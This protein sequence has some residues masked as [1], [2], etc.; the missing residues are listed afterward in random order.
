MTV[1]LRA[2]CWVP[3]PVQGWVRV[4][5][6]PVG[7]EQIVTTG[8]ALRV[9]RAAEETTSNNVFPFK[10]IHIS[11]KHRTWFFSASSED[12]RKVPGG[13]GTVSAPMQA[14]WGP[15]GRGQ[16][17]WCCS[18]VSCPH[19]QSLAPAALAL[20][21]AVSGGTR[22]GRQRAAAPEEPALGVD[23]DQP[24]WGGEGRAGEGGSCPL[25]PWLTCR[26]GWP[27]CARRSATS[28]R[29]RSCLWMPGGWG[30]GA[31][32]VFLGPRLGS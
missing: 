18:S 16:L 23:A 5:V 14:L 7:R 27:C 4:Q 10:I 26:A 28:R 2:W 29:R 8:I 17:G 31:G 13:Q 21:V 6:V 11:K 19:A 25:R 9:M 12:E 1:S 3:R 24:V 32:G 20:T 22:V 15:P 30:L